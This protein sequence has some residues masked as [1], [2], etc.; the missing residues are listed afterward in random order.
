MKKTRADELRV[1]ESERPIKCEECGS[2][3][4]LGSNLNGV[5][6]EWCPKGCSGQQTVPRRKPVCPECGGDAWN[7]DDGCRDCGY[8][9]T[10]RACAWDGTVY[11]WQPPGWVRGH[12]VRKHGGEPLPK[13]G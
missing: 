3:L 6:V 12:V 13:T 2:R 10:T 11:F 8:G 5:S 1:M 4:M 7:A 9:W